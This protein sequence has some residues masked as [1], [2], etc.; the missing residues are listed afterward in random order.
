MDPLAEK[1]PSWS[2][3]AYSF[4]NPINFIDKDG[5]IP[6]PITIRGFAPFKEFG[7]G[8]HGDGRGYSTSSKVTARVHRLLLTAKNFNLR[9]LN[10]IKCSINK[11][12]IKL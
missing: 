1:M 12:F 7:Y 3:Y 2:P 8:F 5:R 4:N 11:C 10:F 6:Y 9:F